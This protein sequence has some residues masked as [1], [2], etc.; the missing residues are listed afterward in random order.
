MIP[1]FPEPVLHAGSLTIHAFRVLLAAAVVLGGYIMVKRATRLGAGGQL[2]FDVSRYA[3]VFGLV[4]A[5]IAKLTM[6]YHAEFAADP[7]I[8][9]TTS[10]G[11]R[12]IG[13]LAGGLAGV[14]V[15]SLWRRRLSL[16]QTV[17]LLD[18]VAF[19]MPFALA[20]GRLGCALVHDHQGLPSQS[21]LAVRFPDGPRYDLGLIECVFLAAVSALF[22]VLDRKPRPTGF[23]VGVFGIIYGVFRIWLDTLHVQ[24][25]RFYEGA[26]LFL[27]GVSALTSCW[28]STRDAR[29]PAVPFGPSLEVRSG[30]T[31]RRFSAARGGTE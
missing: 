31:V 1:Y 6:D 2:M 5:H 16:F 8:V 20:A 22:P 21:W 28:R 4:G 15:C 9:L 12:S 27:L 25:M 14:L 3:I 18:I 10:R 23:F 24:P 29:G 26:A 13:G 11:L 19:A 7:T 17:R 30:E